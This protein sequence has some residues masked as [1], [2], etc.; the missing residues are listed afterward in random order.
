[1]KYFISFLYYLIKIFVR[2]EFSRF[3][4]FSMYL[5]YLKENIYLNWK[6]ISLKCLIMLYNWKLTSRANSCWDIVRSSELAKE[7]ILLQ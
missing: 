2:K 3:S 1:M 4:P 7:I 6:L 5:F